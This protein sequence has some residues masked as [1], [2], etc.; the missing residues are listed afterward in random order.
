VSCR[1]TFI[2]GRELVILLARSLASA[3]GAGAGSGCLFGAGE[4]ILFI[5][6]VALLRHLFNRLSLAGGAICD[7]LKRTPITRNTLRRPSAYLRRGAPGSSLCSAI[8]QPRHVRVKA[9][10][11]SSAAVP[12]FKT[13][14]P[15]DAREALRRS[16]ANMGNATETSVRYRRQ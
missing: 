11:K 3:S 9:A 15:V 7:R 10:A 14:R 12:S 2:R 6:A 4:L 16:C 1:S 8:R 13:R 5:L